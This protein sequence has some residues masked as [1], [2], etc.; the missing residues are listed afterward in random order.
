M[1]RINLYLRLYPS[2]LVILLVGFVLITV[3]SAWLLTESYQNQVEEQL[4]EQAALVKK[5]RDV[6]QK[7]SEADLLGEIFLNTPFR[8]TIIN[9]A[10][11]VLYDNQE[12]P[13]RME[14]HRDRPEIH[15]ALEGEE[16]FTNRYSQTLQINMLYYTTAAQDDIII[17]VARPVR[18]IHATIRSYLIKIILI[19]MIR[20][21]ARPGMFSA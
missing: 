12:K 15:V 21:T 10:G 16:S 18:P 5:T 11:V 9:K 4:K 14:N 2:Y 13:E 1:K 8:V 3:P 6:N 19:A 7:N 17:R 20:E